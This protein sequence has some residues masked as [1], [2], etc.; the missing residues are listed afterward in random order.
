MVS[1]ILASMTYSTRRSVAF[2]YVSI[3]IKSKMVEM[4]NLNYYYIC[5]AQ[6]AVEF[7]KRSNF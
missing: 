4:P 6:F 7:L 2:V 5:T 1:P 3:Q